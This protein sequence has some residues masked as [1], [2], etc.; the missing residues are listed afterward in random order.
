MEQIAADNHPPIAASS[1]EHNQPPDAS[2]AGTRVRD[3]CVQTE[4]LG[5]TQ[6]FTNQPVSAGYPSVTVGHH[7][8]KEY[9]D[10]SPIL[11]HVISPDALEGLLYVYI[12]ICA[13]HF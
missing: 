7:Y 9:L 2:V 1:K 13:L 10:P 4:C 8:G 12:F 11:P 6:L 5:S 3:A